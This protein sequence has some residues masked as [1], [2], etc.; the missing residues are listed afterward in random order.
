MLRRLK[1]RTEIRYDYRGVFLEL[2][3]IEDYE[4]LHVV[5]G[6][7]WSAKFSSGKYLRASN[8]NPFPSKSRALIAAFV[9]I[10]EELDNVTP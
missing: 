6:W 8:D 3:G 7:S 10:D 1:A 2:I 5:D 9:A 4:H